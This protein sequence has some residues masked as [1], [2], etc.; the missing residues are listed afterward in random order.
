MGTTTVESRCGLVADALGAVG[1]DADA[2]ADAELD[3]MAVEHRHLLLL[4][5][6]DRVG[7]AGVFPVGVALE[8]RPCGRGTRRTSSGWNSHAVSRSF[9]GSACPLTRNRVTLQKWSR[10]R[11]SPCTWTWGNSASGV[12]LS[13]PAVRRDRLGDGLPLGSASR[14]PSSRRPGVVRVLAA[15]PVVVAPAGGDLEGLGVQPDAEGHPERRREHRLGGG[16]VLSAVP[17]S[18]G[19]LPPCGSSSNSSGESSCRLGASIPTR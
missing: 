1:V 10:L 5:E 14:R 3:V 11:T 9:F 6:R 16:D 17:S 12:Q 13:R 8:D 15:V 2:V 18:A 7:L 4:G 19:P